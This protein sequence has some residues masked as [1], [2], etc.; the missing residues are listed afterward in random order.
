MSWWLL[1]VLV[2]Y[3]IRTHQRL[4]EQ[5]RLNFIVTLQGQPLYNAAI[6]FDGKPAMSGQ[7]ISL[8]SHVFTVTHPKGESYS[9]NLFV[10][11][12]GHNFGQI[13]LK[14]TMGT[15]TVSAD[16]PA[17]FIF[18]RGPEWSVTLTNSSG[19]TQLVPTDAY[20][21]EADYPR[22]QKKYDASVFASQTTPCTIAPHFGGLKLGCNQTDATYQLVSANGELISD[23]ILPATVAELPAGNYKLVATH[24]NHQRTDTLTVK[25]GMTSD[26]QAD[27]QYGTVTLETSPAGATVATE[28]RGWGETPLTLPE[29][30][31]GNWTFTLQ[32]SGYQSVQVSVNVK[33]N[34][35]SDVSTNLVSE[36]YLHAM[37]VARKFLALADYDNALKA[38]SDA[39][40]ARP[41]DADAMTMQNQAMGLG[42]IRRAQALGKLGEYIEGGKELALALQTLPDNAEAK[43]LVADFKQHEPEEIERLRVER[44]ER[45][46][47]MFDSIMATVSDTD[48][49]ESYELKTSKPAAD[50][51]SAIVTQLIAVQ[52]NFQIVR[53]DLTNDFF[54]IVALQQFSGG[55]RRCEIVGG[56]SKDDETQIYFK[57]VEFKKVGFFDQPI[58]ALVGAMPASYTLINPNLTQAND[59]LRNQIAEGVSNVTVRIQTAIGQ[60]PAVQQP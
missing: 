33:A 42:Y 36:N 22:W 54:R 12:G 56:Q 11:Y 59:K 53:S 21:I 25:A 44:L 5:T 45:P 34:Q 14:R 18:I 57:V 31:P 9:T 55:E 15:L 48:L 1:L 38:V 30:L 43:Q 10:W 32:R 52:P 8:G 6:T 26:A 35:T 28:N 19:L 39:L 4:M 49:F 13:D 17:P 7:K 23:G 16:P 24:H 41:A 2:L 40:A 29:M 50:T 51:H 47:K 58:G 20:E 60:T 3:G 37:N 27:F 46:K